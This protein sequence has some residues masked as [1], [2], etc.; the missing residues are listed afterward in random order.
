M[1][2]HN[3][4]ADPQTL[5]ACKGNI[6]THTYI[7]TYIHLLLRTNNDTGYRCCD[8]P[9]AALWAIA[10]S[11]APSPPVIPCHTL[12]PSTDA[13]MLSARGIVCWSV[14]VVGSPAPH[15]TETEVS[16][17]AGSLSATWSSQQD[18]RCNFSTPAQRTACGEKDT[19]SNA[20]RAHRHIAHTYS[21]QSNCSL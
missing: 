19:V 21:L 13:S 9:A 8:D 11:I 2:T 5:N 18:V 17:F 16:S 7:Y 14:P 12:P 15:C 6:N 4:H 1:S 10:T 3:L 20:T